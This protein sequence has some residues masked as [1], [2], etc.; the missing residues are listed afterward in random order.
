LAPDVTKKAQEKAFI[1]TQTDV[2]VDICRKQKCKHCTPTVAVLPTL[3]AHRL[4]LGELAALPSEAFWSILYF[5]LFW[6]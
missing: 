2:Q 5:G 1:H 4:L 3:E 6:I